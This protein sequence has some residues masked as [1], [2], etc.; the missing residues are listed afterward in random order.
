[1]NG[2]NFIFLFLGISVVFLVYN[3][4]WF[5]INKMIK[6][7]KISIQ[8]KNFL[9]SYLRVKI[10]ILFIF[11]FTLICFLFD[12]YSDMP[13]HELKMWY[14]IVWFTAV[15]FIFSEYLSIFLLTEKKES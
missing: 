11:I 7:G 4:M 9:G 14:G 3:F 1:M 12:L 6:S 10:Q 15:L 13:D 8:D 2:T 5:I